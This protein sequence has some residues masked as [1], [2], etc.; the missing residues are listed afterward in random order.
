MIC[1]VVVQGHPVMA[2]RVLLHVLYQ[3]VVLDLLL[4]VVPL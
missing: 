4:G 1:G 2:H 3:A